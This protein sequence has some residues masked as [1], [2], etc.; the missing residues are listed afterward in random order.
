MHHSVVMK[1]T[2]AGVD[3]W[4]MRDDV[5]LLSNVMVDS[6]IYTTATKQNIS[7]KKRNFPKLKMQLI[8]HI[9][10]KHDGVIK[11]KHFPHYWPFVRG[12]HR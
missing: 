12:I 2:R 8:S 7:N 4:K 9:H 5:Q 11:W 6:L 3:M 1:I 10:S